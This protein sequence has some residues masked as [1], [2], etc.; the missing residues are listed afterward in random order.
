MNA[1]K[2]TDLWKWHIFM[3]SSSRK[4]GRLKIPI[5]SAN[6]AYIS[7]CLSEIELVT[8]YRIVAVS[9]THD[10][11]EPNSLAAHIN[12]PLSHR[13]SMLLWT[14]TQFGSAIIMLVV[15]K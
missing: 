13:R 5:V 10:V 1:M 2:L 8:G 15:S 7:I 6:K 9:H 14:G 11:H 3:F 12:V 4:Q